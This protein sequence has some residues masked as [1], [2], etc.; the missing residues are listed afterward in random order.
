MSAELHLDWAI[1][2]DR[3]GDLPAGSVHQQQTRYSY[4]LRCIPWHHLLEGLQLAW[5]PANRDIDILP[6]GNTSAL[7]TSNGYGKN[8]PT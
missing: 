5:A 7:H 3:V 2:S 4:H 8:T 6:L 1:I